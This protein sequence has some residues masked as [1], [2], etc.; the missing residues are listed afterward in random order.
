MQMNVEARTHSCEI[1]GYATRVMSSFVFQCCVCDF[2]SNI[3]NVP[4]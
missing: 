2:R 3:L 4:S 1:H